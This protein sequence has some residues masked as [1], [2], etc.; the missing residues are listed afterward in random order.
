MGGAGKIP[1]RSSLYILDESRRQVPES[2]AV[3]CQEAKIG[4]TERNAGKMK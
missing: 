2:D 1:G 3:R 4:K